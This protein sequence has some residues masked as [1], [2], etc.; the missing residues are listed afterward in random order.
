[1]NNI[2]QDVTNRI[3]A[4][5]EKG[6]APWAKPWSASCGVP[7][8]SVTKR[9]YSGV[10]ILLLWVAMEKEGYQFSRWLTFK[11]A[12]PP[13]YTQVAPQRVARWSYARRALEGMVI[14]LQESAT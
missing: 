9:P 1:M 5:L 2:Y 11:Q 14:P 4:E 8:N 12:C 13:L 6:C 10:N 3:I 7:M